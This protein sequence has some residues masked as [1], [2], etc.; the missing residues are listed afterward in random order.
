MARYYGLPCRSVGAATEA[1][2]EDIQAGL[3]RSATLLQAVLAG[4]NFVTCGGTLD[5][6]ML[7]S[8][9][10]LMLDDELCG[11]ALRVARGVEVDDGTLA[12]DL[13][14]QIGSTGNYLAEEHTVR[15]FRKEHYIPTL[16]PR[17]PYD[18]WQDAGGRTA[19]DQA[20]DRVRQVLANHRP[21]ELDPA[22]EQALAE[23]RQM[24]AARPLDD[25]Y[26]YELEERQ[27]WENL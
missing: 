10:L 22:L 12:L 6:T 2:Q 9:A 19:L 27:D 5:G 24:I 14:K 7:E 21:R 17:E 15:R 11:A 16:L 8:E 18:A 20:K 25:F 4:V 3:E 26:L 1:K 13:I 23:F